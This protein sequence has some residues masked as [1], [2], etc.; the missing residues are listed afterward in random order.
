L[1]PT[2]SREPLIKSVIPAKAGIQDL[3]NIGRLGRFWMPAF[4]GMTMM[5]VQ[6][7]PRDHPQGMQGAEIF[8]I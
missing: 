7:F 5:L 8:S 1:R 4:A 2:G 3:K 6:S